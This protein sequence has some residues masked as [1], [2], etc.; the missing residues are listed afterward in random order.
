MLLQKLNGKKFEAGD[1]PSARAGSE[2]TALMWTT[3]ANPGEI[4]DILNE[5]IEHAR[6]RKE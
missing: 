3:V 4:Q 2:R 1:E 6:R 5:A